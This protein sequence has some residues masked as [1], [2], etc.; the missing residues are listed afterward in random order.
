MTAALE[1]VLNSK[2]HQQKAEQLSLEPKV[3][4]GDA[5]ARFLRDNE[6]ATKR[7]MAW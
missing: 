2:D 3:M 6:Q 1:K 7:L 5:Y 4:K